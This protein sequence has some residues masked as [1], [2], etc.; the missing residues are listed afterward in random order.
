[1]AYGCVRK[2]YGEHFAEKLGNDREQLA[3]AGIGLVDTT[4]LGRC[5]GRR[6]LPKTPEE[7]KAMPFWGCGG[8]SRKKVL[9]KNTALQPTMEQQLGV[10]AP[11]PGTEAHRRL[12]HASTLVEL[13][14]AHYPG[15]K[16]EPNPNPYG[17]EG[18]WADRYR[19]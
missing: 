1:M 2:I 6:P 13:E 14:P 4:Y 5:C 10:I 19:S 18:V 16:S 7:I 15:L 8:G 9:E 12:S 11:L 17:S 3:L